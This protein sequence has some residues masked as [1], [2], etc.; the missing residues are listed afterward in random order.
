MAGSP[1]TAP[2]TTGRA[3]RALAES[4]RKRDP[5]LPPHHTT[6]TFRRLRAG[7]DT[8]GTARSTQYP[9]RG[10]VGV[11][12]CAYIVSRQYIQGDMLPG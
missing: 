11:Q 10:R 12:I 4:V 2:V 7:R 5:D 1:V 3:A 6:T 8:S 9:D